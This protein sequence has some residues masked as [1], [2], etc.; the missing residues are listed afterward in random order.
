M[1]KCFR[2][3]VLEVMF[4]AVCPLRASV[5][6]NSFRNKTVGENPPETESPF[7]ADALTDRLKWN[8]IRG[9]EK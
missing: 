6:L 3:F 1:I 2:F 7:L 4:L 8:S 9:I 5:N